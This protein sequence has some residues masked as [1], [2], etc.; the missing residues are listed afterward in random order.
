M[1]KKTKKLFQEFIKI[2]SERNSYEYD[3][4]LII[5]EDYYAYSSERLIP[6]ICKIHGKVMV[7]QGKHSS[8]KGCR[9]PKCIEDDK[10]SKSSKAYNIAKTKQEKNIKFLKT[11]FYGDT[12]LYSIWLDKNLSIHINCIKHGNIRTIGRHQ[13]HIDLSNVFKK[14]THCQSDKIEV[15]KTENKQIALKNRQDKFKTKLESLSSLEPHNP[16]FSEL[17]ENISNLNRDINRYSYSYD[18]VYINKLFKN[19][20]IPKTIQVICNKHGSFKTI[21]SSHLKG[22]SNCQICAGIARISKEDCFNRFNTLHGQRFDYSKFKFI[23]MSKKSI[24][25]CIKHNHWFKTSASNHLLCK[26]SGGCKKC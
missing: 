4:S 8:V 14:C 7:H 16:S 2:M 17:I 5:E 24:V 11:T 3:Y 1:I 6:I 12:N 10:L 22:N 13:S 25:R 26:S 20:K 18:H 23:S 19:Y 21:L 9:C 15:I